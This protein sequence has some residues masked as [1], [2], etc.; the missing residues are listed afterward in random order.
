MFCF[1]LFVTA[2]AR[3][4]TPVAQPAMQPLVE[5]ATLMFPAAPLGAYVKPS[6][7]S[8]LSPSV[9][10]SPVAAGLMPLGVLLSLAA[11]AGGRR[12]HRERDGAESTSFRPCREFMSR[13]RTRMNNN[14]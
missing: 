11:L 7:L 3:F 9:R 12:G 4:F 13:L 8:S 2:S 5:P 14:E 6:P 10:A 1:H